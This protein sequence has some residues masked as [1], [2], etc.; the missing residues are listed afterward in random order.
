IANLLWP[1]LDQDHGRSALRSTLRTLTN[2][3]PVEWI[4]ADR[5]TLGLKRDAIR[6]DVLEFIKLL[7]NNDSHGHSSD[8]ICDQCA[9]LYRQAAALYQSDFMAGFSL[10]DS[11]DYDDWQL[12]Q[13]EWL[14][15]EF[16]D[17]LRRLSEYYATTSQYEQAVKYTRQWL[18]VDSLHEPAHR[19]LMYLYAVSGQRAE[20][21][22]QY[23]RIVELLDTELATTPE[24]ETTRLYET[25]LNDRVSGS[26]THMATPVSSATGSTVSVLPPLPS[27]IIGRSEALDEIKQRLGINSTDTDI[28][29][30]TIIQGW[31][32]VGKSTLVAM[33]AHDPDIANQ[34]PDGILWASLGESP[35]I[36]A[37]MVT[38]ADALRL[39]EPGRVRKIEEISAQLRAVLRDKR[40]LLI[41]DDVWQVEHAQ[42]FR[43]GGQMCR[44]VMTSRL[45]DVANALAPTAFDLY[46]LPVLTDSAGLELLEK[47]TPETIAEYS[48]EARELV[49]DLEGLPLAIHVAGRLLHSEARLGWGIRELL[50]ELRMG[51]GLLQAR[52]PSE[53]IGAGLNT[54]PTV[55]VLLNRSTDA[56]DPET[57]NR[58][59][60]L[61]LFAPKPATFDLEAMAVAWD[62]N[63]PR[64][65]AR[66][67]VNRGLLEPINGGRFQMHAVLVLH[68]RSLLQQEGYQP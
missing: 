2:I 36:L 44:L 31:P 16:A 18:A 29:P 43:V 48:N 42:P 47:L 46:R 33:L 61:G 27:L 67:L 62:V 58:F 34:F 54:S 6:V 68:A 38:W 3:A 60:Y 57:R 55:A 25:I 1:D 20:A 28:R 13:R 32:G 37:E 17:I 35:G 15:R 24:N 23:N 51:A 45:N 49:H 21:L 40:V 41:V 56:L 12:A 50:I 65:V 53:M 66:V 5:T 11:L 14:R 22:R 9:E 26:N 19:Q 63:D 30:V 7:S 8:V 52:A 59:A 39:S 10:S 64:P 4:E